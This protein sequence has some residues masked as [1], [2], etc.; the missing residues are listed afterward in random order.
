MGSNACGLCKNL[1]V[2]STY[3]TTESTQDEARKSRVNS[4]V[5]NSYEKW[6]DVA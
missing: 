6:Y 1:L 4:K 3:G 2:G 5:D